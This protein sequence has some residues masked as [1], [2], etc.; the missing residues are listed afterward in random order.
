MS[1]FLYREDASVFSKN[2]SIDFSENAK[3]ILEKRYL[4]RDSNGNV[5]ES[6]EGMFERIADV[7]AAPDRPYTDV[8]RSRVEFYNLLSSKKFFPNSPTFTGAGTPLG[9]LAACFVL[10]I[11][12]DLGK[13]KDGIFSTLRVAS[14]IQQSG[15]VL[16]SRRAMEL[17][18]G[19]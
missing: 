14:L 18:Q 3:K 1:S 2:T 6:P 12:D 15:G 5:S 8:E 11:S 19:P 7:M 4:R 16:E 9:Q 13:E 10:P 17:P